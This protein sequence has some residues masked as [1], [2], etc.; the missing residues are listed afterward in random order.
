MDVGMK[1][2]CPRLFACGMTLTARHATRQAGPRSDNAFALSACPQVTGITG[3]FGANLEE[4]DSIHGATP[5]SGRAARQAARTR[6]WPYWPLSRQVC[7][8]DIVAALVS[9]LLHGCA[10]ILYRRRKRGDTY[11][12]WCRSLLD[13]LADRHWQHTSNCQSNSKW[14][15]KL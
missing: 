9:G 2:R 4:S 10:L 3:V 11:R 12:M 6:V 7:W 14:Q 5:S 13:L 8:L 1:G 15:S